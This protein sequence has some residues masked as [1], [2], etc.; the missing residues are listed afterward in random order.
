MNDKVKQW[1]EMEG[2]PLE[3]S[4]AHKFKKR[5]FSVEQGYF[6][7]GIDGKAR[8]VD[9]LATANYP[10]GRS[11]LRIKHVIECKWSKD[12]PWVLFKDEKRFAASALAAQLISSSAGQAIA[13]I[14][15][16]SEDFKNLDMFREVGFSFSGRQAFSKGNDLFYQAVQGV[17]SNCLNIARTY[18][19][20]EFEPEDHLLAVIALPV[21]VIDGSLF[22]ATY[23]SDSDELNLENISHARLRWKGNEGRELNTIIDIVTSDYL[24]TFLDNREKEMNILMNC[25]GKTLAQ[26]IQCFQEKTEKYL[27]ITEGPRGISGRPDLLQRL[28]KMSIPEMPSSKVSDDPVS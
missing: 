8:E 23:V 14:A 27:M 4:T 25:L 3:F 20:Y 21:I 9:V 11:F 6:V 5:K 24:D 22:E 1:I 2:Y 28:K 19:D 15:A 18:D 13:W 17:V 16:G 12:K 7:K 26:L 10:V